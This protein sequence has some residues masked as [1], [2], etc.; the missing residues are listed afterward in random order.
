[1]GDESVSCSSRLALPE[2]GSKAA[3]HDVEALSVE[4]SATAQEST[5]KAKHA[6]RPSCKH[7]W[8]VIWANCVW[9][10]ALWRELLCVGIGVQ[11]WKV[12]K[13]DVPKV[14]SLPLGWLK[15]ILKAHDT[16]AAAA[17]STVH[18]LN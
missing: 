11:C 14:C 12:Y 5:P 9:G 6:Q 16:A 1:M 2:Q 4:A 18:G 7:L 8:G 13:H 17:A 10:Q 15:V 3:P